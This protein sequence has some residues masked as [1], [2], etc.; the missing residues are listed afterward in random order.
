VNSLWLAF[1]LQFWQTWPGTPARS[2]SCL[3]ISGRKLMVTLCVRWSGVLSL[4]LLTGFSTLA[5]ASPTMVRLGYARCS[6]CHLAPQGAGLLTDY[7]KGIDEA[8]SLRAG[9]YELPDQTKPRILRYD[10]RLL[11]SGYSTTAPPSGERPT[12]PSWFRSYFRNSTALGSHNRIASTVLLEAPQG[13]VDRLWTSKPIVDAAA[14]WEYQ[15]SSHFTLAVARD[16]LPRGVELG[17]T[18]TILQDGAD[19]DRFP[20]QLKGFFTSNRV[21]V[22]TYAYA[23][24]SASATDRRARGAGVL[25]EMQFFSNHLVLGASLRRALSETVTRQTVGSYVRFGVGKWGMLAEHELTQ[26]TAAAGLDVP[27]RRYAG[28]SQF[29]FAPKEWLVTSLIGE[30]SVEPGALQARMFRWRPE[31]QAR[32]TPYV[33]VTASARNDFAPSRGGTSRMYLVQVSVKTVQ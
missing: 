12:P 18:R 20:T 26:Q 19:G 28:Y 32:L 33:T 30:Q 11:T 21:Q 3:A 9:E 24:G 27:P 15:P 16:R 23:P 8:Q 5:T 1:R 6:T 10:L 14:A 25:G 13:D 31:L 22:T 7:G 29:F 2:W 4:M 17:E